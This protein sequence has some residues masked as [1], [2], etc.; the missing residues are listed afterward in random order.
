M[1]VRESLLITLF[2]A[3]VPTISLV[4]EPVMT[5]LKSSSS[6]FMKNVF[7]C[8]IKRLAFKGSLLKNVAFTEGVIFLKEGNTSLF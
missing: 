1:Y 5:V 4:S 2:N 3:F 6:L 7:H 8:A